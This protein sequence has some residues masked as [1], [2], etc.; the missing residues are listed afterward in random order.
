MFLIID[1]FNDSHWLLDDIA[2]TIVRIS[3][4]RQFESC[5]KYRYYANPIDLT[6]LFTAV[7]VSL[8]QIAFNSKRKVDEDRMAN[9]KNRG[10]PVPIIL[11]DQNYFQLDFGDDLKLE[12]PTKNRSIMLKD[13]SRYLISY[14]ISNINQDVD[15]K[16]TIQS[17]KVI[18]SIIGLGVGLFL[19]SQ[20]SNEGL[21]QTVNMPFGGLIGMGVGAITGK[22]IGENIVKKR[23]KGTFSNQ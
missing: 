4:I 9:V 19:A 16:R 20:L 10:F 2:L 14:S 22:A 12:Y 21:S 17:A 23:S 1:L 3:S 8:G 11:T 6:W 18:G 5:I 7:Y 13:Q 15:E